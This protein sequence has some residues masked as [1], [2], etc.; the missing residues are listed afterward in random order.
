MDYIIVDLEA[1]CWEGGTTPE[2]QEI[3]EIGAVRVCEQ[4]FQPEDTFERFV[5]PMLEPEL[6]GFCTWLA[7]IRQDDV[8]GAATLPEVLP[9]FI[10][11]AGPGSPLPP[12]FG[13]RVEHRPTCHA[14]PPGSEAV[15]ELLLRGHGPATHRPKPLQF[16]AL[17]L[18][19]FNV[20][21]CRQ[22][23][24]DQIQTSCRQR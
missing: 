5:R 9:E 3:I 24:P 15:M 13:R 11:W 22:P 20:T 1:T 7:G 12:R 4:H 16:Q 18:H 21:Q 6:S 10:H 19:V 14:H 2:R 8:A 23:A 17:P